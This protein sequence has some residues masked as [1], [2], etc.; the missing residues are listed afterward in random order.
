MTLHARTALATVALLSLPAL[1]R[2]VDVPSLP[3]ALS[4]RQ[5]DRARTEQLATRVNDRMRALQR[6]AEALATQSRTL[7]GDLRTLE[8]ER[9]LQIERLKEAQDAVMAAESDLADATA[10]LARLEEQ[11]LS[12][13]P[14]LRAQLVDVYKRRGG[15]Y[16]RLLFEAE[17]VRDL[18]RIAR[19]VTALTE[20]NKQRVVEHKATLAKLT[21]EQAL[22]SKTAVERAASEGQARRAR[23]A[24]DRAV[25]ARTALIAR[26]DARRDLN[27][28]LAGELQLANDRLRQQLA[29]L[30]AGRAVERVSL[31][32]GP[33]RGSL[34]WPV[35]GPLL[36]RFG[37]P[38][39]RAG[40]APTRS[41]IEIS[42]PTS[43]PVLAVHGGTVAFADSFTGFGN[44]VI[45]DHGAETLTLY[46]YLGSTDAQKGQVI[47][48]GA[49]V[50]RVGSAPAG[51]SALYFEVRVDG[52][53]VD[54]V[55]WL[56]PR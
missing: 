12:Q 38:A 7:V 56:R 2:H 29:N 28:Q 15:G 46:G 40:G 35:I 44:L 32:L 36:G 47:D 51:P 11:R 22:L 54:P 50:G 17:S 30:A 24:A 20:I 37:Q 45:I 23:E 5:T 42:A 10:K 13:V 43:T 19:A 26:I 6:E 16:S 27:A 48:A 18:G 33:F 9:D 52:R 41:G 55:E 14:D 25:A 49:E 1:V 53:S 3:V 21:A 39:N 8:V 34:P 31:P 4:A